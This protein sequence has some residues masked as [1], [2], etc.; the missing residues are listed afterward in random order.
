MHD[1]VAHSLS[2]MVALADGAAV[3][4]PGP[5]PQ[6]R[7]GDASRSRA[8][9]RQALSEMRRLLGVLREERSRPDRAP[10]PD[11]SQLD[12]LL[13][14]IRGP[15]CRSASPSRARRVA[16]PRRR[17]PPST[18]SSRR[19]SPTCSS[20]R[21]M[22]RDVAVPLRLGSRRADMSSVA[23]TAAAR[24]GRPDVPA[25]HGLP[26]MANASRCSAATLSGRPASRGAG[27]W[28]VRAELPLDDGP[29]QRE[30]P[31]APRRRPAAAAPRASA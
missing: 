21:S 11:L 22:R 7:R 16:L 19:R 10:Q 24:P 17:R 6:A 23:T 28:A 5:D 30:H 18:G 9:G 3:A 26:G 12:E 13:D 14:Q 20:T 2:V 8:T 4:R 29:E 27:G 31:G 25:G 1:I 15:G